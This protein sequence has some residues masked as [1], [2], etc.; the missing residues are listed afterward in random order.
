[1][2]NINSGKQLIKDW[3]LITS[4]NH[5][6]DELKQ[7]IV[8]I[9]NQ[10]KN[11][12]IPEEYPAEMINNFSMECYARRREII[13]NMGFALI[14]YDW[15][16][17][18]ARWIGDKRCM[19]IMA[20]S[21]ALTFA[22]QQCNVDVFATDNFSW[23]EQ[24]ENSLKDNA[25]NKT[26]KMWCNVVS[27]DCIDAIKKYAKDLDIVICSWAWMDDTLYK[28]LLALREVNPNC[29]LLYIGEHCGGCTAN[30]D[31]FNL[32]V[33]IEDPTFE[34]AVENFHNWRF[35]HDKPVLYK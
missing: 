28:S 16:K 8:Y 17:P 13:V 3:Q 12:I 26:N 4:E 30:D 6:S 14:S 29:I 1:M 20:G 9:E 32:A 33:E 5:F 15:I 34:K 22:L 2:Y 23:G 10:I 11:R 35:I 24:I 19:E 27:T 21:G 7:Q 25:W 31:F 18:L